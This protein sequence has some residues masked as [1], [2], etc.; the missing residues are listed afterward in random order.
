MEFPPPAMEGW[1]LD[2]DHRQSRVKRPAPKLA[3][4]FATTGNGA[5]KNTGGDPNRQ[6]TKETERRAKR[7]TETSHPAEGQGDD[8]ASQAEEEEEHE[9]AGSNDEWNMEPQNFPVVAGRNYE[10]TIRNTKTQ[11]EHTAIVKA[12]S[13]KKL[14]CPDGKTFTWP[15]PAHI[16]L[17]FR[18]ADDAD[19]ANAWADASAEDDVFTLPQILEYFQRE[20]AMSLKQ[21]LMEAYAFFPSNRRAQQL[22]S[23]MLKWVKENQIPTRWGE[24]ILIDLQSY[25]AAVQGRDE[26]AARAELEKH[27]HGSS[28]FKKM[29]ASTQK[30]T[31]GGAGSRGRGAGPR[32][33]RGQHQG[34]QGGGRGGTAVQ[35]AHCG[36]PGHT[37]S[38]CW[39]KNP[40]GGAAPSPPVQ[41]IVARQGHQLL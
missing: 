22:V 38:V 8:V 30:Q 4:A 6:R 19:Q 10:M 37:S 34:F 3:V 29:L 33:F 36:I 35:C 1:L 28:A 12:T 16:T 5:D 31:G 7:R 11:S 2:I 21:R 18:E 27:L 25:S 39:R 23:F 41:N 9:E 15:S 24:E 20:G 13:T 26:R 14:T 17:K 40:R 32:F